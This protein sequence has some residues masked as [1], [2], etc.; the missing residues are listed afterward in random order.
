MKISILMKFEWD[1]QQGAGK[2]YAMLMAKARRD[3]LVL[4][5]N[6]PVTIEALT[7]DGIHLDVAKHDFQH[8]AE[9]QRKKLAE[10]DAKGPLIDKLLDIFSVASFTGDELNYELEMARLNGDQ[11]KIDQL[12]LQERERYNNGQAL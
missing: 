4:L 6:Q 3:H 7:V 9:T 8:W 2:E 11:H 10:L 5:Y 1:E 12:T